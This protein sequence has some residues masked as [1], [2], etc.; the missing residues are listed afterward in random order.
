MRV[1][2]FFLL[3][4]FNF[5]LD[6]WSVIGHTE[7]VGS[8]VFSPDGTKIA[9]A[10]FDG[11]AKIFDVRSATCLQ[12][13]TG[14]TQPVAYAEFSHDGTRVVTAGHDNV[15]KLFDVATGGCLLTL[16]GHTSEVLSARFNFD[17]SRVVTASADATARIFNSQTG[18]CE[19]VLLGHTDGVAAAEFSSDGARVVTA[20]SDK[21]A[22]VFDAGNG[23]GLHI[24]RH[25]GIVSSACFDRNG[26][27]ILTAGA[28]FVAKLW[29]AVTGANL[30]AYVGH[31]L[32]VTSAKFSPDGGYVVTASEDKTSKLFL[33][34]G[35]QIATLNG[36]TDEVRYAEYSPNGF[37]VI[38]ASDDGSAILFDAFTGGHLATFRSS[39]LFVGC[40][41]FA[42]DSKV[43]VTSTDLGNVDIFDSSFLLL[44]FAYPSPTA[45]FHPDGRKVV[46]SSYKYTAIILDSDSGAALLELKGHTSAINS[47]SY[48]KDGTKVITA[49]DD[50]TAKVFDSQTGECLASFSGHPYGVTTAQLNNDGVF[51]VTTCQDEFARVFDA[52]T[53]KLLFVL[54]GHEAG[55]YSAVFS[56]DGWLIVTASQDKTAR[57][58]SV[59]TGETQ[60]VINHTAAV[61]YAEFNPEGTLLVTASDDGTAVIADA[62]TGGTKRILRGHKSSVMDAHFS[63]DG[64]KVVTCSTDKTARV[65]DVQT[66]ATL[67]TLVGHTD[68]V[69]L[70]QF[71]YDG[72]RVLTSSYDQSCK[73]FDVASAQCLVTYLGQNSH[74]R[75]AKQNQKGTK[76]AIASADVVRIFAAA[77]VT[78]LIGCTR[79]GF[80]TF[81]CPP[82]VQLGYVGILPNLV[83]FPLVPVTAT[84]PT[85]IGSIGTGCW[86]VAYNG[87]SGPWLLPVELALPALL[88]VHS[89]TAVVTASASHGTL[90]LISNGR[91]VLNNCTVDCRFPLVFAVMIVVQ[92]P[93]EMEVVSWGGWPTAEAQCTA[94]VC[95]VFPNALQT[96]VH[97]V[98][99]VRPIPGIL[100][101]KLSVKSPS[102][103][104]K[105]L[106]RANN[107]TKILMACTEDGASCTI[108]RDQD[109]VLFPIPD[110][111]S[112]FSRWGHNS[113]H[114]DNQIP[115]C[116]IS[117][118]VTDASVVAHFVLGSLWVP[119]GPGTLVS[120][121]LPTT[122]PFLVELHLEPGAKNSSRLQTQFPLPLQAT[123]VPE[124]PLGPVVTTTLLRPDGT[125]IFPG[126]TFRAPFGATFI[127]NIS[128]PADV[129]A[130]V[131]T[132]PFTFDFC[133][134]NDYADELDWTCVPCNASFEC[135]GC[136]GK[137]LICNGTQRRILAEANWRSS[138]G[139]KWVYACIGP[140]EPGHEEGVC[141]EGTEGP[142]CGACSRNHAR[143]GPGRCSPC[144]PPFIGIP[145]LVILFVLF[146]AAIVWFVSRQTS[147]V[148][149]ASWVASDA[150]LVE[151]STQEALATHSFTHRDQ[152]SYQ[153]LLDTFSAHVAAKKGKEVNLVK[154]RRWRAAFMVP[155]KQ[156]VNF[157]QLAA[158][159]RG[160]RF[161]MSWVLHGVL[162]VSDTATSGIFA[163]G[164]PSCYLPAGPENRV[165]AMAIG[166]PSWTVLVAITAAVWE[167]R[168]TRGSFCTG[169]VLRRALSGFLVATLLAST[170]AVDE[171]LAMFPC[172]QF[173][174]HDSVTTNVLQIDYRTPCGPGPQRESLQRV[175]IWLLVMHGFILPVLG[176]LA[177]ALHLKLKGLAATQRAFPFCTDGYRPNLWW[178]EWVQLSR[179]SLMAA[180]VTFVEDPAAQAAAA[181]LLLLLFL[182]LLSQFAP[183]EDAEKAVLE[184]R[185]TT[186]LLVVLSLVALLPYCNST[187]SML[188][189]LTVVLA[190][191]LSLALFLYVIIR[192]GLYAW[193]NFGALG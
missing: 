137:G 22:R 121:S 118:S 53:S 80:Q 126:L 133:S 27:R 105:V 87:T 165:W 166:I 17:S 9:T 167:T 95:M 191:V 110:P 74:I 187:Y 48:S 106:G 86:L 102:G 139:S 37:T 130:P 25:L 89:V 116:F 127:L 120:P 176:C 186:C 39:S 46:T 109:I 115:N 13:L 125:A 151:D 123:V 138:S 97:L 101:V 161:P 83:D 85:C 193:R 2:L 67:G 18:S 93:P 146:T 145:V 153:R 29:D 72:R 162:T 12:T 20:S 190:L 188:V 92:P 51:A 179:K 36:H 57:V 160:L 144:W 82:L 44:S 103:S 111:G 79:T 38:T 150:D 113:T 124:P 119:D 152:A 43:V 30:M 6:P 73:L 58:F 42:P 11:T 117:A 169:D 75:M 164:M 69:H 142:A 76:I 141:L 131:A 16:T 156:L 10:S 33:V 148:E 173:H 14:H 177:V 192:R 182:A 45:D 52:R 63:P 175:A 157:M 114:C 84:S 64:K 132:N 21:T 71:S 163:I 8:A 172:R 35:Q 40:A 189:S 174:V 19:H 136:L 154:S 128:D 135:I 28:D 104:G 90:R 159:L 99:I 59:V 94:A 4:Q 96:D 170:A 183:F 98:A 15:A 81:D 54:S 129:L 143:F 91:E 180:I 70:V 68:V 49:S 5:G 50:K 65:F 7:R 23:L 60:A 1:L 158:Q 26:S 47:A 149:A 171:A 62:S 134:V 88:T 181:Q 185:S 107:S 112:A 41:H 24:L 66:G 140:C 108:P 122:S 32:A 78:T 155:V 55:I 3:W 61:N 77:F 168:R 34:N 178:W 56:P 100:T 184:I 147:L 31:T